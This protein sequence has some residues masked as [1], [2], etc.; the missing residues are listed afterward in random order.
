MNLAGDDPE[1]VVIVPGGLFAP[2]AQA[3]LTVA[4]GG[5]K[6]EGDFAEQGEV[7]SGGAMAHPAVILTEGDVEN[8]VQGVLDAPVPADG[9]RQN[10]GI[11]VAA[12]EK[13]ADLGLDSA[14]AIDGAD[15]LDRQQGA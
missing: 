15:R 8:P 4:I 7:A 5:N 11:V 13:V 3:G 10:S 9:S 6:V 12:G 1:H 2:A 14:G